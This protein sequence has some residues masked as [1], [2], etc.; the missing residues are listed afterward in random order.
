[1]ITNEQK[2]MLLDEV[3][4][5]MSTF[6][7]L[8]TKADVSDDGRMNVEVAKNSAANYEAAY[9]DGQQAVARTLAEIFEVT[10]DHSIRNAGFNI[11][12]TDDEK[13]SICEDDFEHALDRYHEAEGIFQ[14]GRDLTEMIPG[15]ENEIAMSAFSLTRQSGVIAEFIKIF[16][17]VGIDSPVKQ[18]DLFDFKDY[19]ASMEVPTDSRLANMLK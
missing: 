1:M 19:L 2:D 12:S 3:E 5:T 13:V 16:A 10:D 9:F 15:L 8:R 14:L 7:A 17:I 18:E 4:K 11:G 6:T